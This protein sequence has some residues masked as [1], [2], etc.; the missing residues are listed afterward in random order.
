MTW[1]GIN[2]HAQYFLVWNDTC[3]KAIALIV[4][5]YKG[6]SSS[7]KITYFNKLKICCLLVNLSVLNIIVELESDLSEC[8]FVYR[9]K[10]EHFY[11]NIALKY[12][13]LG[14]MSPTGEQQ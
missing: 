6:S 2:S 8:P 7:W 14:A 13:D 4:L 11:S 9:A 10:F 12:R 3:Q 5:L 1:Y